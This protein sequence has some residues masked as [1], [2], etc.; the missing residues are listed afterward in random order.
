VLAVSSVL[1]LLSL[2]QVAAA[3]TARLHEHREDRLADGIGVAVALLYAVG[4]MCSFGRP[5]T[6]AVL[7]ALGG[8]AGLLGGFAVGFG[9]SVV[10]SAFAPVPVVL[11]VL[12]ARQE[13]R[14]PR[15][16]GQP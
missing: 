15:Q 3:S 16:G 1:S 11:S 7:F 5:A 4:G 6:A 10:W 13:R 2:A 9:D 8:F 14:L 12:E